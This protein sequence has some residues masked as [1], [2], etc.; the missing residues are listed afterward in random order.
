MPI[1]D[2]TVVE[3]STRLIITGADFSCHFDTV[4]GSLH[5][6]KRNGKVLLK[7]GPQ[8]TLWRAPISNDMEIIDELKR[9]YFLHLEHE[10]VRNFDWQL[11]DNYLQVDVKTLNS[12]TNSAWHYKCH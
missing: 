3:E 8:F 5:N 10:I 12:T 11:T 9:K 1:G 6:L 2:L 4:L 7:Y